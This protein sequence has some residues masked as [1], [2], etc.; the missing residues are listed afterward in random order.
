MSLKWKEMNRK[1]R[2]L[3]VLRLVLSLV[4]ICFALLQLT[5]VWKDANL[6][7]VPL[8]GAVMLVQGIEEWSCSRRRGVFSLTVGVFIFLCSIVIWFGK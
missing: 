8:V 5:D 4:T 6:V 1:N 2:I 3:L 7:A